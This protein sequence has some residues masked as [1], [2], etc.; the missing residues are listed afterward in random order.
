M[1]QFISFILSGL[2]FVGRFPERFFPGL[3]DLFGQSH[4]AFHLTIF[5]MAY[6]Q[7]NAVFEDILSIS[8]NNIQYNL[9]KDILFTLIVLILQLISISLWFKI[10]RPTIE[11]RY[12][13]DSKQ[14]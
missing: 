9:I 2:I 6:S 12:K 11:R 10:S 5:L 3:F 13:I 1:I 8:S 14:Q 4:H 7:A